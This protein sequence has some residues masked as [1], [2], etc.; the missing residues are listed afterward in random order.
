MFE[1]SK[2]QKIK[3]DVKIYKITNRD[4][5]L[6]IANYGATILSLKYKGKEMVLC[7]DDIADYKKQ[8]GYLGATIGRFA[9]RIA[10]ATFT[11]NGVK[12]DL[13]KNF[14]NSSLHGGK[15]GFASVMWDVSAKDN[16]IT[17]VYN[18]KDTEEG[19]PGN[20][21]VQVDFCVNT[22]G[23]V[24]SYTAQSDK[25]TVINLTNHTYF[26]L[27]EGKESIENHYVTLNADY[28]T[29]IDNEY[30]PT[31]EIRNVAN[32]PFDF[33]KAKRIGERIN[34]TDEQL[35]FAGGYDHNFIING[36]GFRKF[37]ELYSK[38]SGIT[39]TC[40]SDMPCLQFYSRNP[41][42]DRKGRKGQDIKWRDGLCL[43]TQ[44][45]PNSVNEPKFPL[46]VLK[47][48]KKFQSKTEYRFRQ[49]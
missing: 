48:G 4:I 28:F 36:N 7:Y 22:D 29:P 41:F 46:Y 14:G 9:N 13:Y 24:L 8:G 40:Y 31:G 35:R 42:T 30:I 33:R 39:M 25:D 27:S 32:T 34:D 17:A 5:S 12:Y 3:D 20:L 47:V 10:N 21:R 45:F 18:S 38:V 37:A 43:E 19:Y 16:I 26:N 1:N 23:I 2:M 11:L 49:K 15:V 44:F 6:T